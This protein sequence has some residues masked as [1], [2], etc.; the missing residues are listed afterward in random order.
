MTLVFCLYLRWRNYLE[1]QRFGYIHIS[2]QAIAKSMDE[3]K[4]RSLIQLLIHKMNIPTRA[5]GHRANLGK[6][7]VN[8]EKEIEKH[9]K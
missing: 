4:S 5:L 6:K 8:E 9:R 3:E 7:K 2:A 1:V